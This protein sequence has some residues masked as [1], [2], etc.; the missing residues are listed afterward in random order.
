M[1][2]FFASLPKILDYRHA[3]RENKEMAKGIVDDLVV[4]A[5]EIVTANEKEASDQKTQDE[6]KEKKKATSS[7]THYQ[8]HQQSLRR[9]R[10]RSGF[11]SPE[12]EID[13]TDPEIKARTK[14]SS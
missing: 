12:V 13:C 10:R 14:C 1:S 9:V 8:L 5:I 4:R 2:G 11:S 7:A 6:E 3:K